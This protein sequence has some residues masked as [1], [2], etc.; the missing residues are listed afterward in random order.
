MLK[1]FEI[2]LYPFTKEEFDKKVAITRD[3]FYAL[4]KEQN[5]SKY[6]TKLLYSHF[7]GKKSSYIDYSIGY[8]EIYY[9][10]VCLC[11]ESKLMLSKRYTN[12]R[13]I[14][15]MLKELENDTELNPK[16]KSIKERAIRDSHSLVIYRPPLYT[17]RKKYLSNY[18][19]GGLYS[20]VTAMSNTEIVSA[21]R[22]DI[23]IIKADGLFKN[24][25]F[26]LSLFDRIVSYIDFQSLFENFHNS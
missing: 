24:I 6:D 26:D 17:E 22:E 9:D 5:R 8:L 14:E 4:S 3:D 19:I 25:S 2:K 20:N 12:K 23:D 13:T 10:G 21:I 16:E 15:K 11:Y 7:Y 1:L 18:H